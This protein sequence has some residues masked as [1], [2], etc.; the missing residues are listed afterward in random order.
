MSGNSELSVAHLL[1]A[2][3]VAAKIRSKK[4]NSQ[5]STL[6]GYFRRVTVPRTGVQLQYYNSHEYQKLS[7]K[8]KYELSDLRPKHDGNSEARGNGRRNEKGVRN[9]INGHGNGNGKVNGRP[10]KN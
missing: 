1:A 8:D 6:G 7:Q 3:P 2:C 5:I 10:W 4:N 9:K